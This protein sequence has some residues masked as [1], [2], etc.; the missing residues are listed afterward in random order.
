MKTT[1]P[2][3]I[4]DKLGYM[5]GDFANDFTF[6]LSSSFLLKFY[7][8]VMGVKGSVVG[9]VMMVA[10]FVDAFTDVGMGRICDRS[11]TTKNGKFKP[12][13][14]RMCGPVAL[15]SFLMYQS[16]LANMSMG[17]K[18]GYLVVTYILWGSVF[19]T[20]VNIPYGS[21]ASAISE[22]PSDRQSLSTFRTM[23]GVLAGG[24]ITAGLPMIIYENNIINGRKFTIV[25]GACSVGAIICY[26]LCYAMVKER[27]I[28]EPDADALK[29]NNVGVMLKN[30][31]S[32]RALISIIVASIVMLL[33][34]LTLQSMSNY[35][36]PNFYHNAKAITAGTGVMGVSMI[37]SA[38]LAK[39][40]SNKIGKAELG[41]IASIFGGLMSLLA[42]FIRPSNVWV[43]IVIQSFTWLGLG[44]FQMIAWALITDVIDYSEIRNGIREDGSVYALYSFA[45]KLGQAAS[46]GLSGVLLDMVGYSQQT[47]FETDVVNGIFNIT[48]LVPAIGF[49]VLGLVLYFWYPLHKKQVDENVEKLRQLHL[50]DK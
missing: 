21:M 37:L 2:F 27:V 15:M 20:S 6:L 4:A 34:Q 38:V 36:F 1:K 10:R 7:T 24:I 12:W 16:S 31:F 35:V 50:E 25:A 43:F 26:L 40:V 46:A 32:N 42:F 5:F 48:T 11:K 47:Q 14:L 22:N 44:M 41:A 39:P 33:A 45:R 30:A 23:G 8:D 17:F 19:Y 29:N 28:V 9:I 18:I 3:G 49:I 13:I